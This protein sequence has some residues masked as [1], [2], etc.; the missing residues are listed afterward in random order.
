MIEASEEVEQC[1]LARS[2]ASYQGDELSMVNVEGKLL[3]RGD[4]FASE[5]E[6]ASYFDGLDGRGAVGLFIL[7]IQAS[8]FLR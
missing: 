3:D 7:L 2:R 1:G 4:V 6:G 8:P 5:L